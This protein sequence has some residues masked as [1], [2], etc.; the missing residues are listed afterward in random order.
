MNHPVAPLIKRFFSHYL[1]II[2]GLSTNTVAAYRDAT[3]L[4]LCYAS[5]T[6]E[7]SVDELQ[8][9]DIPESLAALHK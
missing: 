9:E 3:K 4:L 2:K 1:P 8:I 7:K 5:D 6:L